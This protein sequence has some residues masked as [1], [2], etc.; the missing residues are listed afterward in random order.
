[1]N[2]GV[3]APMRIR[4]R[5]VLQHEVPDMKARFLIALAAAM[6]GLAPIA[7]A[8]ELL[9]EKDVGGKFSANVA[10]TTEYFFRGISQS[11]DGNPAI[12]GGFDFAH[13]SGVYLGTWASSI[14]FGGNIETD[15][16]GG[17]SGDLGDS[18]VGLDV[19]VIYYHYPSA[20]SSD[21]L[22][23]WEGY[24]GVSKDFGV[25]SA[26]LKVSYSP[27]YTID[28]GDAVYLD[29]TVDVPVGKYFTVNLHGGY[30]WVDDNA[31]F[32]F[33]DYFDYLIGLSF[34]VFGFD[35]QVAWL[36]TDL[37]DDQCI[38]DCDRLMAMMS[39]SF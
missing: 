39:R 2:P 27:N 18:G 25:A 5:K 21:D 13:N 16:Y 24:V 34:Q 31:A 15:F 32:G 20:S 11:G 1:M 14:N 30:Q 3:V 4:N 8:D 23:F 26:G 6:I 36:G 29:G 37:P 28:S 33:D 12:Q 35:M 38:G 22:D 9:S 10:L 17:W 19:G 7:H